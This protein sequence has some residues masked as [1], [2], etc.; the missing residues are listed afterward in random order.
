MMRITSVAI[1]AVVLFLLGC[2]TGGRVEPF[3]QNY[4]IKYYGA[5]GNQDGRDLYVNDDGTMILLGNSSS[6]TES[7]MPF[8]AKTDSLGNVLWQRHMGGRNEEA[9]DVEYIPGGIH[10]GKLVVVS[11]I[12]NAG[13]YSIRVTI[14]D[15]DGKGIDSL[16]LPNAGTQF[17]KSITPSSNNDFLVS[18]YEQPDPVVNPEP[19]DPADDKADIMVLRVSQSLASVKTLSRQGGEK[20]G[21]G[22]KV[23]EVNLQDTVKYAVFGYSDRPE[24]EGTGVFVP[25][26]EVIVVN[27]N[28]NQSIRRTTGQNGDVTKAAQAIKVPAVQGDGFFMIGTSINGSGS[29][30]F[31]TKYSKDLSEL[32]PSPALKLPEGAPMEGVAAAAAVAEDGYFLL[33]NQTQNNSNNTNIFLSHIRRDGSKIWS[34]TFGSEEGNDKAGAVAALRGGRIA[35]LG[36]IDLETQRKMAL[37]IVTKTGGFSN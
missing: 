23:F 6:L 2:D 32:S 34:T 13:S 16:V 30:I 4:F 18:G 11:N 24:F 22:T 28:G 10:Q 36:T 19:I 33:A 26:F 37:I 1:V 25:K 5:D 7:S 14:L 27:V 9:V 31:I 35:V 17:A 29:D 12:V 3:F 15:Q 8:I 20:E 21:W